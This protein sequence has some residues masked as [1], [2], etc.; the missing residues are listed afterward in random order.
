MDEMIDLDMA[1]IGPAGITVKSGETDITIR[2]EECAR[3]YAREK[4]LQ[5]SRCVAERDITRLTFVF[6][7]EPK[8]RAVFK[9]HFFRAPFSGQTA[10]RKFRK[11]QKAIENY[12][13]TSYDAS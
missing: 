12:G 11:L 1:E 3:N 2:F 8:L 6:Y 7:T 4:A 13:D 5:T 9:K 10:A